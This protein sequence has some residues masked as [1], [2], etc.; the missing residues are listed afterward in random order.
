[1]VKLSCDMILFQAVRLPVHDTLVV[2][3]AKYRLL[4]NE[5][6]TEQHSTSERVGPSGVRPGG[7]IVSPIFSSARA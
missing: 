7:S 6:P 5:L 3:V 1:M 4:Q 2:D